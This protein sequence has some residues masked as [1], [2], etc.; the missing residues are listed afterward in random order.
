MNPFILRREHRWVGWL[1]MAG[2]RGKPRSAT[3]KIIRIHKSK[4]RDCYVKEIREIIPRTNTQ[5]TLS[6]EPEHP[7]LII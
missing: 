7:G 4:V 1:A 2:I 5:F 6:S 3:M